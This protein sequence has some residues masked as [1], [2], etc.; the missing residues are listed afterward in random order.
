MVNIMW[1]SGVQWNCSAWIYYCDSAWSLECI[2]MNII[3]CGIHFMIISIHRLNT[4]IA[5]RQVST[6]FN[7]MMLCSVSMLSLPLPLQFSNASYLR[8][9]VLAILVTC[10]FQESSSTV[11]LYIMYLN[12]QH[13]H[14]HTCTYIHSGRV[15]GFPTLRWWFWLSSGWQYSFLCLSQLGV[16]CTG[17]TFSMWS[18]MSSW[19][20]LFWNTYHR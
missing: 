4:S 1:R 9:C 15:R 2:E 13:T 5:T 19:R 6:Q 14:A 7:S 20:S 18:L 3:I 8:Y 16:S 17:L 10:A 12:Y 11:W